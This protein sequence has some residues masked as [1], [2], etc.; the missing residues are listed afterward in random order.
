MPFSF[1]FSNTRPV[2]VYLLLSDEM[3]NSSFIPTLGEPF[4]YFDATHPE[5]A[6]LPLV[7]L[8]I[9]PNLDVPAVSLG[10]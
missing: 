9:S 10:R 2:A 1:F 3:P 7:R 8:L 5:I 4:S 6:F